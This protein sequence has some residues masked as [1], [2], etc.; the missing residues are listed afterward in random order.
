ML[1][2]IVIDAGGR[3]FED[4]APT[5]TDAL[6]RAGFEPLFMTSGLRAGAADVADPNFDVSVISH[7]RELPAIPA[8]DEPTN[9][10]EISQCRIGKH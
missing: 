2:A 4:V 5:A 3:Y 7:G 8:C 10:E 6:A 1:Y 9:T